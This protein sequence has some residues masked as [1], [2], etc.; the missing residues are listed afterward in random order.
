M[1]NNFIGITVQ[2]PKIEVY[3]RNKLDPILQNLTAVTINPVHLK[4]GLVD[5]RRLRD[6]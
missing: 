2:P 3:D 1:D 6:I 4:R 5:P